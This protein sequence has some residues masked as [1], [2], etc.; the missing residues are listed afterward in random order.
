MQAGFSSWQGVLH[1]ASSG[2]CSATDQCQPASCLTLGE[3][4]CFPSYHT[5]FPLGK[6]QVTRGLCPK[7]RAFWRTAS[8]YKFWRRDYTSA[9]CNSFGCYSKI[10]SV[11]DGWNKGKPYKIK[12]I[13]KNEIN[14]VP[15][16]IQAVWQLKPE[17]FISGLWFFQQST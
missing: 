15:H 14:T 2:F 3:P 8:D 16:P 17:P 5:D 6:V 7:L 4:H 9:Y 11:L 10:Q 12:W 1:L 13:F